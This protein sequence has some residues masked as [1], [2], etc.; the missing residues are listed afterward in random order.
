MN[1]VFYNNNFL[2]HSS[3][4]SESIEIRLECFNFKKNLIKDIESFLIDLDYYSNSTL[5]KKS[6]YLNLDERISKLS[7]SNFESELKYIF[8]SN[9]INQDRNLLNNKILKTLFRENFSK[10]YHLDI[11]AY[12]W[13][14]NYFM[15]ILRCLK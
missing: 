6:I 8:F 2:K 13:M 4:V 15:D 3:L 11:G 10:E 14:N 9:Y 7:I 5:V 12:L 1:N